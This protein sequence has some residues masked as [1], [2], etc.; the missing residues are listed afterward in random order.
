[1]QWTV[2]L[3][4]AAALIIVEIL[5]PGAFFFACLGIGAFAGGAAAY[6]FPASW[7]QWSVFALFSLISIYGIRPIAK[8]FFQT[9]HTKTNTDALIG[10][11]AWVTETV[12]PPELGQVKVEGE[13]WR[14]EAQEFIDA[15]T[16]VTVAAVQGTRLIVK[17]QA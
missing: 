17:K 8:R 3:I 16:F 4:A 13:I 7:L 1:M 2:W 10:K 6:F 12:R 5:T 15:G 14:A 9:Q 11:K